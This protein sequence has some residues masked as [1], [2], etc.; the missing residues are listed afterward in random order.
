MYSRC[1]QK[2]IWGVILVTVSKSSLG[3]VLCA[4]LI[5]C[6]VH[7]KADS[8]QDENAN[9]SSRLG[10]NSLIEQF[11]NSRLLDQLK[12]EQEIEKPF[13]WW[14]WE[15]T[16]KGGTVI[17]IDQEGRLKRVEFVRTN[18]GYIVKPSEYVHELNSP[19]Q[20]SGDLELEKYFSDAEFPFRSFVVSAEHCNV[21][22]I[23]LWQA[24]NRSFEER[25]KNSVY[26]DAIQL[27]VM[28]EK[29]GMII[30]NKLE[31]LLF[32]RLDQTLSQ[33]VNKDGKLDFLVMGSN[34]STFVRIWTVAEGC[35]VKTL[36][37][38]EG[39]HLMES[40]W[41]KGVSLT[42]NKISGAYDIHVTHY[43]PITKNG[44]PF[45]DV[46]ET[47]YRWD[48]LELV[49]KATETHERLESN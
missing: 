41:D 7:H 26:L 44:R 6:N 45:L 11:G 22:F 3:V 4:F 38:R 14:S 21:H 10:I 42:K 36:L 48:P 19:I 34:M 23:L 8:A 49:Y 15:G 27:R 12:T 13:A 37:F 5:G 28:V 24:L 16:E 33:D 30:S 39:D 40:V 25:S 18:N 32:G 47:V 2:N 9:K 29:D 20:R 17:G 31:E 43:E 46:R 1:G 35:S